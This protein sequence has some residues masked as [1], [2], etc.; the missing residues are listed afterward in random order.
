MADNAQVLRLASLRGH[1][2]LAFMAELAP[3]FAAAQAAKL[4][5]LI[6]QNGAM[7]VLLPH[8]NSPPHH[9][10]A[11][12]RALRDTIGIA[13]QVATGEARDLSRIGAVSQ[14]MDGAL[15]VVAAA[16]TVLFLAAKPV[17]LPAALEARKLAVIVGT[18]D[19]VAE[20]TAAT[21]RRSRT[22]ASL[23]GKAADQTIA[24]IRLSDLSEDGATVDGLRA[25]LGPHEGG[26]TLLYPV[27]TSGGTVY[28]PNGTALQA[29]D[30]AAAGA[31]LRGLVAA[32]QLAADADLL[33]FAGVTAYVLPSEAEFVP[34]PEVFIAP[35]TG[36]WLSLRRLDIA[37]SDA[38]ATDLAAR[39]GDRRFPVGYRVALRPLPDRMRGDADVEQLREEIEEREAEIALIRALAAPQR[40]LLRFSDAQLPA[41]V[42]GL[43]RMPPAMQRNANLTFATAHAA[44]RTG[45]A[46]FVMYDPALVAIEGHLP[47]FYWRGQTEDTP[48]CYWVDP[49]SA[50]AMTGAEGEPLIFVPLRSHI[51]PPIASFGGRLDQ[52][53]RLVLGNLFADAAA[54]L[55][56]KAARPVFVFSSPFD[57]GFEMEVELLDAA[58][59]APLHLQLRWINDHMLVRSPRLVDD[60][61]LTRL[62]ENLYEGEAARQLTDRAQDDLAALS[63]EW[64]VGADDLSARIG[65]LLGELAEEIGQSQDRVRRAVGFLAAARD[66]I[67]A[68]DAVISHANAVLSDV[69]HA[70]G[71]MQAVP[72]AQ[73][74][75]R[76]AFVSDVLTEIASGERT[77]AAAQTKIEDHRTAIDRLLQDLER[78][79]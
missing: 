5:F 62:A 45:P 67:D 73:A 16:L 25:G 64:T 49:P 60:A 77:L 41:L 27:E 3:H 4:S 76:L 17:D 39:I 24:I 30:R 23:V 34:A 18:P 71:Q 78:R 7:T 50:A 37:P 75:R 68:L 13:L 42:D 14:T 20:L 33:L 19:R 8:W 59:F 72:Q 36:E 69:E 26:L 31:V 22:A 47:E 21:T 29:A 53:M 40:R 58:R 51:D 35:D 10:E 28:L 43:R 63:A 46:H 9:P 11:A 38:A 1:E 79:Q 48:I 65:S 74:T 32:D 15:D 55:E 56:D 66:R 2:T 57:T 61:V 70:A 52:T 44:G 54:V 6:A 12:V